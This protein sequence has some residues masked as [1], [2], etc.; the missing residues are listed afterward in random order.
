MNC[1]LRARTTDPPSCNFN[2][3]V[4]VRAF[5]LEPTAVAPGGGVLSID[6]EA[7]PPQKMQM[8]VGTTN[9]TNS[10]NR[11]CRWSFRHP[12]TACT[13]RLRVVPRVVPRVV[14]RS[15]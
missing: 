5:R 12:L 9:S 8:E 3:N 10:V 6:G 14:S 13:R 7:A 1:V 11:R 4:K 2:F 15:R